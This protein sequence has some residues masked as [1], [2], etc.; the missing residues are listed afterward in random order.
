MGN[1]QLNSVNRYATTFRSV[2]FWTIKKALGIQFFECFHRVCQYVWLH[3]LPSFSAV[4]YLSSKALLFKTHLS[5]FIHVTFVLVNWET[6]ENCTS[7]YSGSE[8]SLRQTNQSINGPLLASVRCLHFHH[9][10]W[11][12]LHLHTLSRFLHTRTHSHALSCWSLNGRKNCW[13]NTNKSWG[14]FYQLFTRYLFVHRFQKRK[15]TLMT[16]LSFCACGIFLCK[17]FS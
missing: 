12:P 15:K 2:Y 17:S 8:A 16:W 11:F 9:D 6:R 4:F 3:S 1:I 13:M 5:I 10:W 14:Q 7:V